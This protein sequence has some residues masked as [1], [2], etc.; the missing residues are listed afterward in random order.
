MAWLIQGT[1]V[2]L[3][4]LPVWL[5]NAV[6]VVQTRPWG[7]LDTAI[8][9]FAALSWGAEILADRQKSAWKAEQKE[10]KHQEKFITSGLWS[11][12][13]HPK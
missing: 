2:S 5:T 1:W 12:S 7:R 9:T 13:R 11:V 4:G 8:I 3:I 6:P 10:G